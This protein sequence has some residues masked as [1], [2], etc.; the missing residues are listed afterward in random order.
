MAFGIRTPLV[1]LVSLNFPNMPLYIP[2]QAAPGM[3]GAAPSGN[4]TFNGVDTVLGLAPSAG[5]YT[6]TAEVNTANLTNTSASTLKPMGF[7]L[8]VDGILANAGTIQS[9]GYDA[10]GSTGGAS[11]SATGN[12]ATSAGGGGNGR[13]TTGAGAAG[14][15]SGGR[16]VCGSAGGAGGSAG[17]VNTGGAGNSTA[18]ATAIQGTLYTGLS[19]LSKGRLWDGTS[20]NGSGGGGGGGA[21]VGTGTAVS[22]GGGGAAFG[23]LIF[24]RKL[25]NTGTISCNG[26]AGA[27]GTATGNGIAGGGGGGAGGWLAIFCEEVIAQ[28]TVTVNGGAIGA[29]AGGAAAAVA[30]TKGIGLIFTPTGTTII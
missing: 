26:G 4:V 30:G 5:A 13:N 29:G 21:D 8:H 11:Q 1:L 7:V 23:M 19:S 25:N 24:C 16:N 20:M 17:G 28:G 10:S 9:N 6:F 18:A 27:A 2:Q 3:Y 12:L 22:G 15:G 14:S